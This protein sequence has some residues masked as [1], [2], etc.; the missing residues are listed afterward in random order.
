[1]RAVLVQGIPEQQAS[2]REPTLPNLPRL[3]HG[4]CAPHS[5][6]NAFRS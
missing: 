5:T 1:M 2:F 4:H 3:G 6:P